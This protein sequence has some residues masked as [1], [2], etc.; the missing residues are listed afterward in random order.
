MRIEISAM[1]QEENLEK[2]NNY[3]TLPYIPNRL[4]SLLDMD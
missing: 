2:E 3:G 1:R 4:L